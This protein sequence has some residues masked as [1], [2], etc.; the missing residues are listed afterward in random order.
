MNL[1]TMINRLD[2]NTPTTTKWEVQETT[3]KIDGEVQPWLRITLNGD[4][5]GMYPVE[6]GLL[7][8]EAMGWQAVI[9]LSHSSKRR[10]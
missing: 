7:I 3:N 10:N 1:Q 8:L 9:V 2:N 5:F 6:T 4:T